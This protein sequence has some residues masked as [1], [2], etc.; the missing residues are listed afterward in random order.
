VAEDVDA[1]VR[2]LG[3]QGLGVAANAAVRGKQHRH[4]EQRPAALAERRRV[5]LHGALGRVRKLAGVAEV[6]RAVPVPLADA[7]VRR[8]PALPWPCG[9]EEVGGGGEGGEA[10][11]GN[12]ARADDERGDH[13]RV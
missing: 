11:A 6:A 8:L 4:V 3:H 5:P 12:E 10:R 9:E 7:I 2:E 13:E 1:C